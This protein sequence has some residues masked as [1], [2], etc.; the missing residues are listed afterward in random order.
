M[1]TL[2]CLQQHLLRKRY[3]NDREEQGKEG[4]GTQKRSREQKRTTERERVQDIPAGFADGVRVKYEPSV[5][6]VH[7][8]CDGAPN[9]NH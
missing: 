6:Q 8:S 5:T 9:N 3:S 7:S 1:P 2:R 4:E